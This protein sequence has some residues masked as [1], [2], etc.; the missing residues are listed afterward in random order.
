VLVSADPSRLTESLAA[1]AALGFDGVFVHEV[2]RDQR[3]TIELF[4]TEVLPALAA[5][6]PAPPTGRARP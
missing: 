2:G 1:Y 5:A 3:R 6:T 4:G